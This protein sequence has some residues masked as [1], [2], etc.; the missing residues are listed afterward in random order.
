MR[1]PPLALAATLALASVA[2][3]ADARIFRFATT[4]NTATLDP[5]APAAR[6]LPC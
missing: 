1:I 5:H 2:A 3:D 6:G 4:S